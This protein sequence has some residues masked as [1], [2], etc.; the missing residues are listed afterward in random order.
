MTADL[1]QG[2]S[3]IET[4]GVG[5][6]GLIGQS[7]G[8]GGGMAAASPGL[9]AFIKQIG[10]PTSSVSE[11]YIDGGTVTVS[12]S[13]RQS[14]IS[15]SGIGGHGI[16]AQSIGG[17]GGLFT[18][19]AATG[20]APQLT[21]T[22]G[23]TAAGGNGTG[24]DVTVNSS[25]TIST[26]GAGAFGILAQ[27]VAGGGGMIANDGNVF[28]GA[29][30]PEGGGTSAGNVTVNVDGTVSATGENSIG[31]FA[32]SSG[33][34]ST[35]AGAVT[36][37][38]NGTVEGGTGAQGAGILVAGG[39]TTNQINIGADGWVW[40]QSGSAIKTV[41]T[42]GE[43][44]VNVDNKGQIYG[45]TWLQ[46][47]SIDGNYQN[48]SGTPPTSASGTL[49]NSGILVALPGKSSYVDGHVIQ[50]ATGWISPHLDYSNMRSG[51]YIVTGN[52]F[53]NGTIRP[54]LASAMPNIFLP[55][56]RVNGSVS[57]AL[58]I[59]DS[60]L[61]SYTLQRSSGQYDVAIT[62]THFDGDRFGLS[63]H[64]SDVLRALESVFA[65][66]DPKLGPFFAR[67]DSSAG[68]DN[69]VF[70]RT[71][72]TVAHHNVLAVFARAA[73]DSSRLADTA[74]SCQKYSANQGIQTLLSESSCIQATAGGYTISLKGDDGR[75]HVDMDSAF[76]QVG[77][78]SEIRPNLFL[79][80]LLAYK[81]DWFNSRDGVSARGSS[82]Q[83]AVTLK[84]QAGPLLFSGALFGSVGV[85]E[86]ERSVVVPGFSAIASSSPDS[87]IA[88]VRGRVAY[89]FG[90][91]ELYLR[92][93]IGIDLIHARAEGFSESGAG[94]LGLRV[95][96]VRHNT[97]VLMPTVEFGGQLQLANEMVLRSY[98]SGGV[99]VRSNDMWKGNSTFKGGS[100]DQGFSLDVPIDQ[101][102]G[103][104]SAGLQLFTDAKTDIR[105]Q[106]DGDF[107]KL[108]KTHGGTVS[109][110]YRF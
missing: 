108:T 56:L 89:T 69:A 68:L 10:S 39:N 85:Y 97:A 13:Q 72:H 102:T 81:S 44:M 50:T 60:P 37:N 54:N 88:G 51:N 109:L 3:K 16:I 41:G 43:Q 93:S 19:Y 28:V 77:G 94:G 4:Y 78:Q 33:D 29:T 61:F 20:P 76:W 25:A 62:G 36:V 75:G 9:N 1:G 57:D 17:G 91:D 24:G 101:Y 45:N 63:T 74:L 2:T 26:T 30:A 64:Q 46:G 92:P 52:A 31:V 34:G 71:L 38:V 8:G 14:T 87:Y 107:G 82:G 7:V 55:A 67:L 83:S 105:L 80:G 66:S 48:A 22:Y 110:S 58:T 5:A 18:G 49:T 32:Q 65:L 73:A 27:S 95:D 35:G 106:Y 98:V 90:S 59:P 21:S 104:V 47:G 6:A 86:I 100:E 103:R 11:G 99:Q 53:L 42:W 79:G 15:T 84:Y 40:G 12:A 23:G 96:E 70:R